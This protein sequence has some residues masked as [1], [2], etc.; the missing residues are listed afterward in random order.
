MILLGIVRTNKHIFN[1]FLR[2]HV[3]SGTNYAISRVELQ[4]H[5]ELVL[6]IYRTFILALCNRHTCSSYIL[7]RLYPLNLMSV[8]TLLPN[9]FNWKYF[10]TRKPAL[11]NDK[12]Q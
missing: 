3:Y 5:T 8:K 10:K 6:S 9:P 7:A 2:G 4:T 1:R 11:L 12:A